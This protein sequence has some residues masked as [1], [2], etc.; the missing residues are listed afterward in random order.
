MAA[1]AAEALHVL[2]ERGEQRAVLVLRV[3]QAAGGR[4]GYKG[5]VPGALQSVQAALH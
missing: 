2:E 5:R 3:R 1:A 4:G